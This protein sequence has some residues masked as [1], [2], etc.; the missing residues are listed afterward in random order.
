MF[1]HAS[2]TGN[3]WVN[4]RASVLEPVHISDLSVEPYKNHCHSLSHP[5]GDHVH[6]IQ[7]EGVR[8]QALLRQ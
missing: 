3:F 1:G 4:L 2:Y 7:V 6:L 8:V 5:P